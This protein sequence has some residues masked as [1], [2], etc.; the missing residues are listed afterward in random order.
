MNIIVV[1]LT[2]MDLFSCLEDV[3]QYT[4]HLLKNTTK[5]QTLSHITVR[6]VGNQRA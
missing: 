1:N 4:E 2:Y 6:D 5:K 3:R